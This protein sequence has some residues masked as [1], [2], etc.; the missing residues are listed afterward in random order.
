MRIDCT[1]QYAGYA[2]LLFLLL[3]CSMTMSPVAVVLYNMLRGNPK[4]TEVEA[5]KC[6][7]MIVTRIVGS[8]HNSFQV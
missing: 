1:H 5:K 7:P 2:G 6:V 8:I 4:L 3:E